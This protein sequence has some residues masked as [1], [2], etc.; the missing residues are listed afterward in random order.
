MIKNTNITTGIGSKGSLSIS[1]YK[2]SFVHLQLQDVTVK[3]GMS[4]N[5]Y[6]GNVFIAIFSSYI[7]TVHLTRVITLKGKSLMHTSS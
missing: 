3:E 2:S 1:I 5:G 4:L 6:G 7:N